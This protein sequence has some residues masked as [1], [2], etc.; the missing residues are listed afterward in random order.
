M[1]R[2]RCFS[3]PEVQVPRPAA[4]G[5]SPA[6]FVLVP[7]ACLPR[8]TPNEWCWQQWVYRC[9]FAEADAVVR[10]SLPERNLL[11]VWN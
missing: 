3:E 9:A 10:P 4:T 8:V 7:T 2:N 6:G 5:P 1:R 11:A